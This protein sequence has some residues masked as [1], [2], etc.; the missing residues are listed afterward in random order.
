MIRRSQFL[1]LCFLVLSG[2]ATAGYAQQPAPRE[3]V[4]PLTDEDRQAAFPDLEG[5]TTHDR[6]VNYFVLFDQLEWRRDRHATAAN[7]DNKAWVGGDIHR[8]WFRTEGETEDGHLD[9]AQAHLLYGRSFSPWWDFVVGMRQDFRPGPAQSW[10]AFGIQ[11]LAPYWF[12]VE[13]TGYVGAGGRFHARLEAEYELLITNRLVMQPLVEM[14]LFGKSDSRRSIGAG[15]STL[16]TG[17]RVRYEVRREFAPYV[18]VVWSSKF[19]DTAGFARA[20]GG[21]IRATRFVVGIRMWF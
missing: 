20:A 11:G 14:E 2:L 12:E 21:K 7:W 17:A 10:A 18:G 13:A 15:L 5:H 6:K 4:P 16:E 19:G 8:A 3:P 1:Y 9:E